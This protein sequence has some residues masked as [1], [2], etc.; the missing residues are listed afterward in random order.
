MCGPLDSSSGGR[1]DPQACVQVLTGLP[2]YSFSP[3]WLNLPSA[4]LALWKRN[5]ARSSERKGLENVV[6]AACSWCLRY[7]F[8]NYR[9]GGPPFTKAHARACTCLT[10]CSS[11]MPASLHCVLDLAPGLHPRKHT[12]ERSGPAQRTECCL[13]GSI[14][15]ALK[16]PHL[17]SGGVSEQVGFH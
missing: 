16:P 13:S 17:Q 1:G 4:K 7:S 5:P 2:V 3:A 12:W 8:P 14:L 11:V 10:H 6:Q 9:L 15:T